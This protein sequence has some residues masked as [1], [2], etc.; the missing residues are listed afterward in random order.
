MSQARWKSSK[1]EEQIGDVQEA[2]HVV[3]VQGNAVSN[4]KLQAGQDAENGQNEQ[5][6]AMRKIDLMNDFID[7]AEDTN[8]D[9]ERCFM[10]F[11]CLK[12]LLSVVTCQCGG[13]LHI[14]FGDKMGYSRQLKLACQDCTFVHQQFSCAR[15][16]RTTDVTAD[17]EVNNCITMCFNELGCGEA[18]L[19]KFSGIM[20]IP[21]FC[22]QHIQT[23]QQKGPMATPMILMVMWMLSLWLILRMRVKILGLIL[24]GM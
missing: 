9:M 17:F 23:T 15:V 24:T 4:S 20:G 22:T 11:G 6:A 18:A 12:A 14:Q 5:C 7:A 19:R 3:F 8:N 2:E 13:N 16:G 1:E 21:G 10:E